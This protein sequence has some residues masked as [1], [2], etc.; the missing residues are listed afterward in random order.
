MYYLSTDPAVNVVKHILE[1][2]NQNRVI[3]SSKIP[4]KHRI[5]TSTKKLQGHS[6]KNLHLTINVDTKSYHASISIQ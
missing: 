3:R 5:A 1:N 2:G 6:L 4:N